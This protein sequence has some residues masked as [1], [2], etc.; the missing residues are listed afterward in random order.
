[1]NLSRTFQGLGDAIFDAGRL[2]FTGEGIQIYR[3]HRRLGQRCS[4]A[5]F[6]AASVIAGLN[7]LV[8][9]GRQMGKTT[10]LN[11]LSSAIPSR[12]RVVTCEEVFML[13]IA[14]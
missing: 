10:M 6:L 12:E 2:L 3:L 7:I 4:A 9:G 1:M 11:C 8:A 14:A 5:R 13:T